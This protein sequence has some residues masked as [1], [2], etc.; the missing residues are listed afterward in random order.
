[1]TVTVALASAEHAEGLAALFAEAGS[2]C[3]CRFWHFE[4]DNNAWLDRCANA[5]SANR[6]ELERALVSGSDEAKGVVALAPEGGI[7][8]WMKVAPATVMAK[9]YARRLY[10]GLPCF[11]GDRT[12]V[13]VVG[14]ALVHPQHRKRGVATALVGGAVRLAPLWGARSLEAFPRRP[15]EPVSDD[16]LWTGPFGAF[17][18]NG[19]V[20]VDS[21]EPYPVL[22]RT[23]AEPDSP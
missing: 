3:Y 15:R 18:N 13:F 4:G 8:G 23:F 21:F 17:R 1:V 9:V 6:G 16:E 20:E 12:G 14:C 10:K 11:E 5:P 2:P 22:R 19:F 7:L